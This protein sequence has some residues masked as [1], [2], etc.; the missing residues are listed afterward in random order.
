VIGL[1]N[2]VLTDR[3]G[4]APVPINV[5]QITDVIFAAIALVGCGLFSVEVIAAIRPPK[6]SDQLK[7]NK[8]FKRRSCLFYIQAS[9]QPVIATSS[10]IPK[11]TATSQVAVTLTVFD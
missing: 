11:V 1:V 8:V 5:D 3:Q 4:S 10:L 7:R 6:R 9:N 2:I